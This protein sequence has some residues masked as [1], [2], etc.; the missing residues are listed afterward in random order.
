MREDTR[1]MGADAPERE[2]CS[3]PS[4]ED[5][6]RLAREEKQRKSQIR[7]AIV[8][9]WGQPDEAARSKWNAG[10]QQI[11]D[12]NHTLEDIRL[13]LKTYP[14]RRPK[15]ACNP[16]ALAREIGAL[17]TEARASPSPGQPVPMAPR[18]SFQPTEEEIAESYAQIARALG[19]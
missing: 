17:L 12:S 2:S 4:E 14:Q 6:T 5:E 18:R 16:V 13:A 10:I 19:E 11:A 9:A 8:E 15:G 7:T 1:P 3:S